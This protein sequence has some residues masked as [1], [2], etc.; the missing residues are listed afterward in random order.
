MTSMCSYN[1]KHGEGR[2]WGMLPC[3]DAL[4]YCTKCFILLRRYPSAVFECDIC[5]VPMR[6]NEVMYV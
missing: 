1:P 5:S 2:V 4:E 3:G 6:C